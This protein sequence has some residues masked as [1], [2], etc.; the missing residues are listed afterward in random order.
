MDGTVNANLHFAK[1]NKND[2]FYTQL[3]DI[4]NELKYYKHHFKGKTV[5]LNCDNENS[6]F[7][8]YFVEHYDELKLKGLKYSWYDK[9]TGTGDFRSKEVI[10]IMKECDIVVTNPPFSLFR[11]F[12]KVMDDN[13]MK[14]LVIGNKN[15]ITYKETFKLIKDNK[16]WLGVNSNKTMVYMIP[17]YYELKGIAYEKD[18]VKYAKV[19][20]VSWFTNLTH[21]KIN[22]FL[23]LN[24]KYKG[25]E[26]KYPK[27]DNYDAINVD[28][29]TDIPMDYEGAMGVPITFL[30]KFNPE[31]F[32]IVGLSASASYKKEIVGLQFLGDN[33]SRPLING[34]VK[35]ARIVIKH[36]HPQK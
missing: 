16:L 17:D 33:D 6:N 3:S 4:E 36:K 1:K 32:D 20:S 9:E 29:V 11:D 13:N 23:I 10:D 19:P 25:N 2:E 31:Q 21:N 35:Y 5:F 8:K 34:V 24:N 7:V 28:K 14:F 12:I 27:Y 30:T 15:A 18:G 22:D 26:D